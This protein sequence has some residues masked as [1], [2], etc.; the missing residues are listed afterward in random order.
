MRPYSPVV[1]P[2]SSMAAS[3]VPGASRCQPGS[4]AAQAGLPA[5]R[6]EASA[7]PV[8]APRYQFNVTT[9]TWSPCRPLCQGRA[10]IGSRHVFP[11]AWAGMPSW[12]QMPACRRGGQADT[13]RCESAQPGPVP[14]VAV[15]SCPV[16]G[17]LSYMTYAKASDRGGQQGPPRLLHLDVACDDPLAAPRLLGT[18]SSRRCPRTN[19]GTVTIPLAEPAGPPVAR[20]HHRADA[21]LSPGQISY[22]IFTGRDGW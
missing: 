5:M 14:P 16:H 4:G 6:S 10:G 20:R 12:W 11:S 9:P 18:A 21:K 19:R 15:A 7:M 3:F 22:P 17:S 13:L 1:I 2:M 8:E